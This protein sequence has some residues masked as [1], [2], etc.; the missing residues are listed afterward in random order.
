MQFG[1]FWG[2]RWAFLTKNILRYGV[3]F[4]LYDLW[5]IHCNNHQIWRTQLNFKPHYFYLKI[6]FCQNNV[7]SAAYSRI[8][9]YAPDWMFCG[10]PLHHRL[11]VSFN[12]SYINDLFLWRNDGEF[13]YKCILHCSY[14]FV[15]SVLNRPGT[16]SCWSLITPAGHRTTCDHENS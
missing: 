6:C 8:G 2:L 12:P 14:K 13:W 7:D 15:S 11:R 4:R 9:S 16:V 3:R 10:F 1:A 5:S